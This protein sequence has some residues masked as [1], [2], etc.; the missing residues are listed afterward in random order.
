[1]FKI[2]SGIPMPN[3]KASAKGSSKY[4]LQQMQVGDSFSL[5][6]SK[7]KNLASLV[8]SVRAIISR[9][10]ETRRMKFAF[11]AADDKSSVRVWRVA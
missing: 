6:L 3:A 8:G 1:M 11:R 9:G 2:D 4:P 10:E 7:H 5:P